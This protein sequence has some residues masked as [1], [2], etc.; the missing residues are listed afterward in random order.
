MVVRRSASAGDPEHLR[1]HDLPDLLSPRDLLVVNDTTV[2]PARF[3]GVV[4]T[5]G[6]A[7][8]GLWL[9][10]ET[11]AD[12]RVADAPRWRVMLRAKRPKPGR[13]VRLTG[14]DR[15]PS[16]ITI[17][18][19]ERVEEA[20]GGVWIVRVESN[21]LTTLDALALVGRPP[22]PPYISKARRERHEPADTD[23]DR[24]TYQTLF[25][26]S[27]G[28]AGSVAAPTAGLHFTPALMD[29]LSARAVDTTRVRLHVGVG[30]FKPITTDRVEQ[31]RMHAEWCAM[32]ADARAAIF[33]DPARR[34]VAVG[35][36]SARTIESFAA[37]YETGTDP[38]E[39]ET[40]LMITPG[41]D[42]RRVN[43]MMT[44]FHLPRSTLLVM[45]AA[46]L[47]GGVERLLDL[48]RLA[49]DRQ[50]R[51]YSYGDAMLILP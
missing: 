43:A 15:E 47:E 31:H 13:R 10:N 19:E 22:L 12:D 35:S 20:E 24:E 42:W 5:T 6:G 28:S 36:T 37:A 30:T 45:V 14:H 40:R 7:V 51:F 50:Y 11:R 46:L 41:Y 32:P 33:D 29:R 9:A 16:P 17:E 27:D 48:Y 2:L 1:V 4:E 25:A 21:G 26:A 8:E 38:R 34:V 44:N 39:L 49:I 18:L 23:D 3:E